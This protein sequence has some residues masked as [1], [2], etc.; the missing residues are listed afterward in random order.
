MSIGFRGV[1]RLAGGVSERRFDAVEALV[2]RGQEERLFG[3]EQP[4]DVGLR[5]ADAP[6]DHLGGGAVQAMERKLGHR[7]LEHLGPAFLGGVP[8]IAGL[9]Y[10]SLPSHVSDYSLTSAV[11]QDTW[12]LPG[13]GRDEEVADLEVARLM[14]GQR[15]PPGRI[16]GQIRLGV[17]ANDP[18]DDLGD[19]TAA[20]LAQAVATAAN[21]CLAA[22]V[23]P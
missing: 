19:D 9:L 5:D 22:D 23:Q 14:G 1:R 13:A 17:T 2:D 4:E 10:R 21:G 11:C 20:D 7:R 15:R 18:D 8:Q 3:R 6:G 16:G 12:E